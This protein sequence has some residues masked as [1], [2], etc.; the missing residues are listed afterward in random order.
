MRKIN[1]ILARDELDEDIAELHTSVSQEGPM[2]E[3]WTSDGSGILISRESVLE[4]LKFI[5]ETK[6][7]NVD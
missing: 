6:F 5:D 7:L 1:V 4:I 2:L 3:M